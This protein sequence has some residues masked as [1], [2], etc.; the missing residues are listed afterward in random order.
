MKEKLLEMILNTNIRFSKNYEFILI[1]TWEDMKEIIA[2]V[3]PAYEITGEIYEHED[4]FED[5]VESITGCRSAWGFSDEHFICDS[6]GK[7]ELYQNPFFPSHW[8]DYEACEIYCYR[9]VPKFAEN[10][11]DSLLNNA[12]EAND[13]LSIEQLHDLGFRRY[14][15]NPWS[16]PYE[17]TRY[18]EQLQGTY[19]VIFNTQDLLSSIYYWDIYVRDKE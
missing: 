18:L 12:D 9:C 17:R 7:D 13:F 11:I 19:D 8:V 2:I 14:D 6:C 5:I 10:Y 4:K 1:D 16:M 15:F 3:D